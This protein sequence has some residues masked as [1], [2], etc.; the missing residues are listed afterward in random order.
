[1]QELHF[2]GPA[3]VPDAVALLAKGEAR[4]L[5]GGTDLI[6]Q[7]REGRRSLARVV[8][9]KRIPELTAIERLPDGS[10]RIGA[11]T[12]IGKLGR[13][14]RFASEHAGLLESARLVGS[15]Q[16]QSR[17]SL[18]GNV[19]NAAPS[20]DAVPLLFC[21]GAI[22]EIAGPN[23]RRTLPVSAIAT[24][25]GR[26]ALQA[27]ELLVAI[28]LPALS[29]RWAA[30]Y[31]RFTPR[32]EMDIA[33]AGVGSFLQ[34]DATGS[35]TNA[36]IT[37]ASVAPTPLIATAAGKALIGA[38]P[39]AK[40]FADAAAIAAGEAKPISDTRGSADYRRELVGVLTRRTLEACA[41][42]IERLAP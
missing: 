2:D 41:A 13:D 36:C 16:V 21:L 11:A 15:L 34:V 32:R 8:D 12:S 27:D 5:A 9:L 7:M 19:C 25:P 3:T 28:I 39:S 40:L 18:G 30:R 1:M 26:T 31:L 24:G 37:L 23:G 33:I 22:G 38:K 42:D 17:A 4:V 14:M 6:P 10:W 35:I 29:P 20:A